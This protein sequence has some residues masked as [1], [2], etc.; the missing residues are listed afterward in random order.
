MYNPHGLCRNHYARVYYPWMHGDCHWPKEDTCRYCYNS[1][2]LNELVNVVVE[3]LV[4]LKVAT[5]QGAAT[6]TT[7]SSKLVQD[8]GKRKITKSIETEHR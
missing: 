8:K 7:T 1:H 6:T 3:W 5:P 4:E 2:K